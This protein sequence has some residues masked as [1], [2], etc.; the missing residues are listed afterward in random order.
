MLNNPEYYYSGFYR[1]LKSIMRY[2]VLSDIVAEYDPEF[3]SSYP[4]AGRKNSFWKAVMYLPS[5]LAVPIY[6][7]KNGLKH[8]QD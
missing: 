7:L 8:R 6:R 2:S 3:V 5:K 4:L 1:Y